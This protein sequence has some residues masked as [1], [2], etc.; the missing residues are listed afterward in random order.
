M[1]QYENMPNMNYGSAQKRAIK[2]IPKLKLIKEEV[3]QI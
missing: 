3:M 2:R 1:K